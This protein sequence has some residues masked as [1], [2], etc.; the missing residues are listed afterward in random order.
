MTDLTTTAAGTSHAPG[1]CPRRPGATWSPSP[2]RPAAR[3]CSTG[4]RSR[5]ATGHRPTTTAS[6][7]RP[8]RLPSELTALGTRH[9]RG[10]DL[11]VDHGDGLVG[12]RLVWSD[13]LEVSVDGP[14]HTLR[15]RATDT[16]GNLR[17]TLVIETS[18][19]H[20]AVRKH[21]VIGN[22]GDRPLVL[23]RAFAPAWELPV[24]PGAT[25][26]LLG[27]HWAREFGEFRVAAAGR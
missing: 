15:A 12:A 9:T 11:I 16:T 13:D 24:G 3:C 20:D 19:E 17:I 7:R 6:R 4:D 23:E 1:R 27:G 10:T 8:D 5:S 18:T 2:T 22:A 14:E 21:A 25:V 26:D